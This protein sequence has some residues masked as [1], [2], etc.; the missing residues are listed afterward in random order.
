MVDRGVKRRE[1]Y[2]SHGPEAQPWRPG[3]AGLTLASRR[4]SSPR[5]IF[6]SSAWNR[7]C[8]RRRREQEGSLDPEQRAG[9]LLVG[10]LQPIHRP[11]VLPEP[12]VDVRH[13]IG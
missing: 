12:H 9:S 13:V 5:F 1:I 7:G 4:D 10:A 6:L 3:V 11:F 2:A 8:E